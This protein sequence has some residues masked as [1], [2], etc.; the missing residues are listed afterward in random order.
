MLRRP[1]RSTLFPYTTL[2]RSIVGALIILVMVIGLGTWASM[3]P[4]ASGIT[5]P[6]QVRVEANRKTLRKR[7]SGTVKSILVKEGQLVRAGQPVILFNDTE[8]KASLDVLQNQYD[9]LLTQSARFSAEA[10]NKSAITFPPEI[11]S[12]MSDPR[13]AGMVR[14]QEFLFATRL[15]LFQSQTAVLA[16]RLDQI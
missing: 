15:Q 8:P 5:A 16:Q 7:E 11:T 2:F 12:R 14:D 1:P 4:L 10:T 9:S 13:V 6:A 3:A